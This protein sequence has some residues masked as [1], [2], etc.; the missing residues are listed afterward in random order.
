M[1]S[2]SVEHHSPQEKLPLA[3]EELRDQVK[4]SVNLRPTTVVEKIVLPTEE[5]K[6]YFIL[7]ML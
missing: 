4:Q 2:P 5:G 6:V 1:A 3:P 7:F